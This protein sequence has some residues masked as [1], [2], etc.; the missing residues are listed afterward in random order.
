MA[1]SPFL[2]QHPGF[3]ASG[4]LVRTSHTDELNPR[5]ARIAKLWQQI[6]RDALPMRLNANAENGRV[7][8]IY[9]DYDNLSHGH[10]V[11]MAGVQLRRGAV[12]S[13]AYETASVSAG[14]YIVFQTGVWG[15]QAVAVA[16]EGIRDFF[17]QRE[18]E[19]TWHYERAFTADFEVYGDPSGVAIH[20]AVK[21]KLG[22]RSPV[23]SKKSS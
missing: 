8:G 5:C 12:P 20:V 17:H 10:V 11:F 3:I 18:H 21:R 19:L 15:A 4:V 9:A 23:V 2:I 6:Y 7:V 16:W 1:S 22:A 14:E 13:P